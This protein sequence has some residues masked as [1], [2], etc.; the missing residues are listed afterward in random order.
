MSEYGVALELFKEWF[1]NSN[2]PIILLEQLKQS[3][4][5]G[6]YSGINQK[7]LEV[8]MAKKAKKG[9]KVVKK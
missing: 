3:F 8:S 4:I 5:I 1:E 7:N 2:K 9:K 6:Y